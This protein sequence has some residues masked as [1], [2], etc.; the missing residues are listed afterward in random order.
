MQLLDEIE[1]STLGATRRLQLLKGDLSAIP[2]EH[3]VDVLVVSAFDRD[4]IPT[5]SSLIGA[6]HREGVSVEKLAR[7]PEWDQRQIFSCW[8]SKPVEANLGFG[9]HCLSGEQQAGWTNRN[10]GRFV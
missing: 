4:Y 3:E 6:L 1:I 10:C 2:R 8:C 7:H 9:S 5:R